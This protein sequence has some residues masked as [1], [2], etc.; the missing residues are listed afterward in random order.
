MTKRIL[1]IL[2]TLASLAV[3]WF[4]GLVVYASDIPRTVADPKSPTDVI[5]VLTGGSERLK[6]GFRLLAKKQAR[7]LF[8]S[9]VYRGVE[10]K[11]LLG[12]SRAAPEDILCCVVLGHVAGDTR[13]NATE[14]AQWIVDR[15][16]RS[17][18]LVTADYH[19]P[20]SL[21]EFQ[22]VMPKIK[23]VPHP[24]FPKNVRRDQWW[25]YLGTSRLYAGEFNKYLV[26]RL[27][28]LVLAQELP[29]PRSQ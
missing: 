19:M 28:V 20:R 16:Y 5:V 17:I 11:E 21:F 27:R 18:R 2:A 26:A 29:T 25:K 7:K 8:V 23:I 12:L 15:G 4:L 13:G 1:T 6:E 10:V 3:A 14:T 22:Q 24:V 9:G